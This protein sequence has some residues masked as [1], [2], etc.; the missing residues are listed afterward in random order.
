MLFRLYY[1]LFALFLWAPPV[2]AQAPI[3]EN[4]ACGGDLSG[5]FPDCTV[6]ATQ[7]NAITTLAQIADG[8]QSA[9]DANSTALATTGPGFT[10][11]N[12]CVQ[13]DAN[14]ALVTTGSACGTGA[15]GNPG[16]AVGSIQYHDTGSVFNGFGNYNSATS[17]AT[18]PGPIEITQDTA[19]GGF[20]RWLEGS[21]NGTDYKSVTAP[22]SVTTTTDVTLDDDPSFMD[23]AVS[24]NAF[25]SVCLPFENLRASDTNIEMW[26]PPGAVVV[27]S[28]YCHCNGTCTTPAQISFEDRAGNAMTHALLAC[29]TGSTN[30]TIVPV[31]AGGALVVGEGL[32]FDV[33]NA[34]SPETDQ[35]LICAQIE[36]H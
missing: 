18:F 25:S 11:T 7:L 2:L 5:A 14:G 26:M 36:D 12:E 33:D 1:L 32:R 10:G 8:I 17:T 27:R 21:S 31:T 29:S 35:Y 16:G 23:A 6:T 30:S 20:T 22:A 15:A 3:L 28:V 24:R 13:R 19:S 34:V 4:Q 9:S